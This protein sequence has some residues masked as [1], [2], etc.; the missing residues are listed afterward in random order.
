MTQKCAMVD[1]IAHDPKNLVINR[2]R[3]NPN[4]SPDSLLDGES[5]E[6]FGFALH[7]FVTRLKASIVMDYLGAIWR[8]MRSERLCIRHH[9][10]SARGRHLA[11]N[12]AKG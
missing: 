5:R 9:M 1:F 6:V 10:H 3:A 2:C 4:T 12:A 7:L 11:S 8:H